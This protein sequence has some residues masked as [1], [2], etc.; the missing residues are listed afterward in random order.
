MSSKIGRER[1]LTMEVDRIN[2]SQLGETSTLTMSKTLPFSLTVRWFSASI[3]DSKVLLLSTANHQCSFSKTPYFCFLM[4]K[5]ATVG[6]LF[7]TVAVFRCTRCMVFGCSW[8]GCRSAMLW[9]PRNDTSR[10][11]GSSGTSFISSQAESWP[12]SASGRP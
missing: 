2:Y 3:I 1:S 4:G 9:S 12:S 5:H 8:P 6:T 10:V 7:L 11:I